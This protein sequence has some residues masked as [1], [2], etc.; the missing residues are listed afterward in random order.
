MKREIINTMA[1][2]VAIPMDDFEDDPANW[3]SQ[4]MQVY[5]FKYLLAHANDGVIWGRLDVK[6][7]ITSHDVAPEHSPPLRTETL[8][9]V[10]AF[11]HSGE[12]LVWR[13]ETSA[14]MGRLIT[15]VEDAPDVTADWTQTFEERQI[16]WGTDTQPRKRNFTV[17]NDGSQGLVHV[18]P[19]TITG[20]FDEQTRPLRLFVRHYLQEDEYG[21]TRVNASRLFD[22]LEL[23]ES[24]L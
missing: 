6:E 16:L 23:K 10:R 13:D 24:N 4:Q 19:L 17:M 2:C 21:F 11:A 15:E 7:L 20:R 8:Q 9:T 14:W 1:T 12:L 22:L 18:V 3:L 5:E